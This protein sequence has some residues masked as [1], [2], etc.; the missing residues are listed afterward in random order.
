LLRSLMRPGIVAGIECATR[1]EHGGWQPQAE[2]GANTP[3]LRPLDIGQKIDAAIKLTT[4]NFGTLATIVL[5]VAAPVQILTVL[6][7][8]STL[9]ED[10]TVTEGFGA[11]TASPEVGTDVSTGYWVGLALVTLLGMFVYL[12]T[13]AGCFKAIGH[14][15]LGSTTTWQ[16]SIGFAT[17]RL[18]AVL[19][20]SILVGLAVI[21]G[22]V[23]LFVGSIW[24]G[25]AFSLALPALLLEDK[26]GSE[27]LG[28]SYN[29]IKGR[30]WRSFGL[31]MAGYIL[32]SVIAGIVQGILA[33]LMFVAVGDDSVMSVILSS[34][35]GLAGQVITTPFIAA[36]TVVLYFDLR[37][38]KEAFDLQLL[39][40]SMGGTAPA[41]ATFGQAM[42]WVAP[43]AWGQQ[44]PQWGQAPQQWGQQQQQWGQPPPAQPPPAGPP[45]DAPGEG[46][47]W[48]Q[49]QP[50]PPQQPPAPPQR[51]EPP[52]PP[53]E[54]PAPPQQWE[55]PAP[56]G[57]PDPPDRSSN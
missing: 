35:A 10:Y 21:G 28:R 4:R 51:W 23:L 40:E 41:D 42:P 26:K 39:A 45:A 32:A 38:R 11:G 56:P 36:L 33:A 14:A 5:L 17:K 52:A 16:D 29:L 34:L 43:P 46:P 8:L 27:A 9:P 12:L 24:L 37:V 44:Q 48:G 50:A 30:W 1:M 47:Q 54:P 13:T 19:W 49:P 3:R 57:P 25:I 18:P 6:V 15:Y 7:T 20:V 55:P 31:L 22:V 53:A 2:G